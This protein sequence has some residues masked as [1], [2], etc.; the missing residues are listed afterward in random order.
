MTQDNDDELI[1]H[2][3]L[4]ARSVDGVNSHG[5]AFEPL[6]GTMGDVTVVGMGECDHRTS[7]FV[8]F[9]R[10]LFRYLVERH[11]VQWFGIEAPPV[12]AG[13]LHRYV[14]TGSGDL[15]AILDDVGYS[16]Y[17]TEE[18]ADFFEWL[19]AYNGDRPRSA[20]VGVFGFDVQSIA[21]PATA[22]RDWL[23]GRADGERAV[24]LLAELTGDMYNDGNV[25]LDQL[26]RAE[27]LL[28]EVRD[29]V[30]RATPTGDTARSPGESRQGGVQHPLGNDAIAG[31]YA[32]RALEQAV[33][34]SRAYH[35][36][37]ESVSYG[38]RDEYMA[39]NI[40]RMLDDTGTDRLAVW[41][42]DNHVKTGRLSRDGH[43][44]KTMG[45]RLHERLG[46][47][48]YALG[49]QFVG[50]HVRALVAG[51]GEYMYE[52]ETLRRDVV[53][54]PEPIGGSMPALLGGTGYS[55][56]LV[57]FRSVPEDGA[58]RMGLRDDRRNHFIAGRVDPAEPESFY[59]THRTAAVF[60]GLAFV[61]EATPTT[62]FDSS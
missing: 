11:G 32:L 39:A 15:D 53:P 23:D 40:E 26:R 16:I 35:G 4:A 13:A 36:E 18:V 37:D 57:D 56:G 46:M 62:P 19:R 1:E 55:T 9:K 14:V 34:F 51:D 54:V 52:G 50:G 45:Q 12:E 21:G 58:L 24:A 10:R 6:D 7:E 47:G 60:D 33:A 20:R 59:G 30:T 29:L 31:E 44:S 17:R 8:R 3:R 38:L 42:H 2:L 5:A 48:Y 43:P 22:L 61:R 41:A 28:P 25:N 49:L 27:S